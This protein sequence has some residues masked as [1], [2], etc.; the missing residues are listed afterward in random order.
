MC[1]RGLCPCVRH[2]LNAPNSLL[3]DA[4]ILVSGLSAVVQ[5]RDVIHCEVDKDGP[6]AVLPSSGKVGL[7]QSDRTGSSLPSLAARAELVRV[8]LLVEVD[9]TLDVDVAS[10]E[11]WNALR[12]VVRP[13][14]GNVLPEVTRVSVQVRVGVNVATQ[15]LRR[16]RKGPS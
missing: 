4:L 6:I 11:L 3:S 2:A 13:E 5:W 7:V 8:S 14:P 15:D 1:I 9:D 16:R 10:P 12:L